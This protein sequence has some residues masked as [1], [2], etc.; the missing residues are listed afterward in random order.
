LVNLL[1][2]NVLNICIHTKVLKTIVGK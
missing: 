1:E 2:L